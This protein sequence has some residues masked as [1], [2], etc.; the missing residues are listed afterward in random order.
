MTKLINFLTYDEIKELIRWAKEK[1]TKLAIVL[2]AGS[3]L[4]ISEIVGQKQRYTKC[5]DALVSIRVDVVPNNFGEQKKRKTRYCINCN[6]I[7]KQMDVYDSKKKDDW[8]IP[9]LAKDMVD[10]QNHQI[11]IVQGKGKKDRIT[12]TSP[13]LKEHH[14]RL[15]PILLPQRTLQYRFNVLTKKV[16]GKQ[17]NFHMLR[18]SFGNYMVV[19]KKVP[20]TVVQQLMGHARV[21]VTALY[22]QAN[23]KQAISSAWEAFE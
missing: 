13:W 16:I 18:H 15:L 4:R 7:I 2:G 21:D 20:M 1:D 6:K 8:S 12:V 5:C 14:L 17:L 19:E 22:S 23:P 9:P 10:L 3:G 11:R